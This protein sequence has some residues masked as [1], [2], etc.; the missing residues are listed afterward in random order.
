MKPPVKPRSKAPIFWLLF[1]GGGTLAA[2]FGPALVLITGG[3]LADRGA[4]ARALAFAGHPLARLLMF[5]LLLLL[6]WHAAHRL[7]KSLH[8]VGIPPGPASQAV[9]YGSAALVTLLAAWRLVLL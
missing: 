9:C 7:Y 4:Y 2:L 3:L 1:G 5:G 6:A 8:D